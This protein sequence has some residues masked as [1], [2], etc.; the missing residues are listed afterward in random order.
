[1]T[2]P[3]WLAALLLALLV[4]LGSAPPGVADDKRP[5]GAAKGRD[6]SM[7]EENPLLTSP[8]EPIEKL[9]YDLWRELPKADKNEAWNPYRN[10][11][12]VF[13]DPTMLDYDH[14]V[15]PLLKETTTFS[16]T[17]RQAWAAS[18]VRVDPLRE[19]LKRAAVQR[20]DDA[21]WG[22]LVVVS[23]LNIQKSKQRHS[24]DVIQKVLDKY[25]IGDEAELLGSSERQ[26][27]S[28][29]AR[30]YRPDTPLVFGHPYDISVREWVDREVEIAWAR[31][32]VAHLGPEAERRAE[33]GVKEKYEERVKRRNATA[34][35]KLVTDLGEVRRGLEARYGHEPSPAFSVAPKQ[36]PDQGTGTQ[37]LGLQ[38]TLVLTAAAKAANPCDNAEDTPRAATGLGSMLA[39]P[40]LSTGGI[41]FSS[42][43]LRYL[44]DPGDGSGLAYSFSA[45]FKPLKG[46]ARTATGRAALSQSSDAFFV[47]LSLAPQNFWVNLN[48]DEPERIVDGRL[49]RTDAGKVMLEADLE[50]KKTVGKLIHPHSAPGRKF[51]AGVR[52]DCM[53]FR[54]WILPA[55]ASVHQDGDKLYILDA[56]LDVKMETQYLKDN[57]ASS[58]ASCPEQDKATEDHNEA[59]F[60]DLILPRLKKAINTAPEY[61]DLRRVYLARVAAEWYRELSRT[62]DTTYGDLI[63][64]GDIDNW[65]RTGDWQPTDTFDRYV[66]S[67]TKGEFKVTDRTTKGSTT[68]VRS[69]VYGGVDLTRIPLKTVTDDRFT[70]DFAG[71]PQSVDR[72]LNAPSA[73][74]GDETVWLGSP[75]P[76]QARA[77]VGAPAEREAQEGQEAQE[78]VSSGTRA[79]WLLPA[80]LLVPIALLRL[81]RRRLDAA[82]RANHL[83]RNAVGR[84]P[85]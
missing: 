29:C 11:A 76:R 38:Q 78:P 61:A 57:G 10:G 82:R 56:P 46:D 42:M 45:D 85:R 79:L 50:M 13:L 39:A 51:W 66:D 81:R 21:K 23:A 25:G 2:R 77:G 80:L 22:E 30:L 48:P 16:H 84:P 49:G 28:R 31:N 20:L 1:M 83:R 3:R 37:S 8:F 41:D 34:K 54:N 59:L 55:T 35:D 24:E 18:V 75:T 40:G 53:S 52:G 73:A 69:Y 71:L 36:C 26:N 14:Q 33:K 68:Y 9:R 72:S 19:Y 70:S 7:Q 67:Y 43:E 58:A 44:S 65:R 62:K 63:D 5:P 15:M 4:P 12:A 60:R 32:K 17:G 27:C 6:L 74:A 64:S 47:W